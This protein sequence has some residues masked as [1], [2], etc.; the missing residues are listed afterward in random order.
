MLL[1]E[2]RKRNFQVNAEM[3]AKEHAIVA[4]E[5]SL[6]S[7]EEEL[8]ALLT[9]IRLEE[10]RQP[11]SAPT[12]TATATYEVKDPPPNLLAAAA[13]STPAAEVVDSSFEVVTEVPAKPSRAKS[14][15]LMTSPTRD[16]IID[17]LSKS[18]NN[19]MRWEEL[20]EKVL[21]TAPKTR[22]LSG[23][24]GTMVQCGELHL[25]DVGD[26]HNLVYRLR[27]SMIKDFSI[28]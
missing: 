15:R 11:T 17:V 8:Q 27:A 22:S 12:P 4:I 7:L 14:T 3:R 18:H 9:L 1:D 23:T 24:I 28:I 25:T 20:R 10:K 19:E 21:W 6:S 2:L 16:A 5:E 13:K 26:R